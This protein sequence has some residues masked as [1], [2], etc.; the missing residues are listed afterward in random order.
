MEGISEGLLEELN[1]LN[2]SAIIAVA[3]FRM[4]KCGCN[5]GTSVYGR[6]NSWGLRQDLMATERAEVQYTD[7]RHRLKG[8]VSM[9]WLKKIYFLPCNRTSFLLPTPTSNNKY[10]LIR[11]TKVC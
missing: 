3:T 7:H 10:A 6:R 4:S 9:D 11:R 8:T 2:V 1:F 5:L